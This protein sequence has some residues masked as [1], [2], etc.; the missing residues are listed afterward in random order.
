M[1]VRTY[2]RVCCM[3]VCLCFVCVCVCV[4]EFV[5]A[6]VRKCQYSGNTCIQ[7]SVLSSPLLCSYIRLFVT[8]ATYVLMLHHNTGS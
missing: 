8:H 2:V 5:F 3:C 6:C 1:K 4:C 7:W